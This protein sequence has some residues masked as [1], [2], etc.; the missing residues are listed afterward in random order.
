MQWILWPGV[1]G[2]GAA[3]QYFILRHQILTGL[4][5][6]L[7]GGALLSFGCRRERLPQPGDRGAIN[8]SDSVQKKALLQLILVLLGLA[9]AGMAM[10]WVWS[11]SR[12]DSAHPRHLTY[13]LFSWLVFLFFGFFAFGLRLWNDIRLETRWSLAPL[14]ALMGLSL[15]LGLFRLTAVPFTVHGDEGMVGLHARQILEGKIDTFFS[16]SWY[17]IPQFF[18]AVPAGGL[19]LLGDNLLGLRASAVCVGTLS[20][21][22][23]YFLVRGWWGPKSALFATLALITNHWFI[24]LL[25]C[26]VNY[27]Q[28]SFFTTTLLAVWAYAH[29]HQ[30]LSA[31]VGA[32]LVM[33]LG[34]MSYQ[35]NHLLPFL[36]IVSQAWACLL[37]RPPARWLVASTGVPLGVAALVLAPLLV[38]DYTR[39]G[40]TGMFQNRAQG[41]VAWTPDNLRH[42]DL[43]YHADGDTSWIFRRQMERAFL[44]PILYSDTSMQYNGQAPFLDPVMAVLFMLGAVTAAFRFYDIRWSLPAG[45]IVGIL[46]AGGVL[47]VDAPF[48]PRLAGAAALLFLPVAGVMS[49]GLGEDRISLKSIPVLILAM[50][51][52]AAG[53][54]NLRHYFVTYARTIDPAS[55]HYAQTGLAYAVKERDPA[56]YA[57]VFRGPHFSFGSGTVQFLAKGHRGGDI[58]HLPDSQISNRFYFVVEESQSKWLPALKERF[59]G[60][61]IREYKNPQGLRLFTTLTPD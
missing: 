42:L 47:T 19:Y 25:H 8:P 28:V 27:V 40:Q 56:E 6:Y 55:I 7:L 48:F 29:H 10:A 53:G 15:T 46:L 12:P 34:L 14:L 61:T 33:G 22:P 51:V 16:T 59:P 54:I 45:W 35:A 30:S 43:V 50:A 5:L 41:V 24:H 2:L 1:L 3:A 32:G 23:F 37:H 57:Y 60:Y 13:A 52:L 36:W 58:D 31:C 17:A 21:I 20:V 9:A 49:L 18:F 11:G 38:H 39:T 44:S 4:L 26:G